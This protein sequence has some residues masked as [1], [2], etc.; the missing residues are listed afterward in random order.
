M[1]KV[2][3][4]IIIGILGIILIYFVY[5]RRQENTQ[6]IEN[7][8][9]IEEQ[10]KNVSKIIVTE[11]H[12]SEIITYKDVKKYLGNWVTFDK[13]ALII[14]NAEVLIA[15]DL[16]QVKYDIQPQN[17]KVIITNIPLPEIKVYPKITYYDLVESQFNTFT[18]DDHNKIQKQAD[19]IIRQKVMNSSM[20]TNAQNRLISELSKILILTHSLQWTLQYNE[21]NIEKEFDFQQ[22]RM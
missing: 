21:N 11:G 19:Q 22:I 17:K 18:S 9:L 16:N 13:K 4:G 3:L 7:T 10:I 20:V 15:Y 14:V 12:F 2:L 5:S 8:Q 1:K 6:I